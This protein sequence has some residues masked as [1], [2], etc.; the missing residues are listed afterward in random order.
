MQRSTN[1]IILLLRLARQ[2]RT[3]IYNYLR[4]INKANEQDG[5]F[6]EHAQVTGKDYEYWT[7]KAWVLENILRDRTGVY[8][9]RITDDYL[10]GLATRAEKINEKSMKIVKKKQQ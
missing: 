9:E 4:I 5:G 6:Q 7:R 3:D 8:P 1:D 10:I 2:K